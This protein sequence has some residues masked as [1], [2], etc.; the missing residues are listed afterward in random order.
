M[1]CR[2]PSAGAWRRGLPALWLGGRSAKR[3]KQGATDGDLIR[4]GPRSADGFEAVTTIIIWMKPNA[5]G[6]HSC[7]DI[8]VAVLAAGLR[9]DLCEWGLS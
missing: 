2:G 8:T 6:H 1:A 7:K 9:R 5:E 3:E 4:G